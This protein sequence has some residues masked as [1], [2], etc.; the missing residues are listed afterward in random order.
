[1]QAGAYQNS[2]WVVAVAKAGVEDGFP[3]IGG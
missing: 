1:V 3:M 2:C